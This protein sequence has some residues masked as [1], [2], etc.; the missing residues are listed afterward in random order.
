MQPEHFD[1][2]DIQHEP[3]D[4]QLKALMTSVAVEAR[5]RAEIAREALMARLRAEIEAANRAMSRH[6]R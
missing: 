6:E 5:R 2:N 4:Q 1:L 3:T